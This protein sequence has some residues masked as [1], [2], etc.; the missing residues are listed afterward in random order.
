MEERDHQLPVATMRPRGGDRLAATRGA[1]RRWLRAR[2]T[3]LVSGRYAP[4][5][6]TGVVFSAMMLAMGY[7]ADRANRAAD[8]ID[9]VHRE[10]MDWMQ[11]ERVRTS[12]LE[13]RAGDGSCAADPWA[14][15]ADPRTAGGPEP[16]FYIVSPR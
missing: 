14:P 12:A 10:H 5:L 13:I 1:L 6:L 8:A 2:T 15:A 3:G 11:R 9:S 7:V 4:M 16:L